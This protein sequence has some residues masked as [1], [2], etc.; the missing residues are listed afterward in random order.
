MQNY[1]P[2]YII[3]HRKENLKK[4]S[5]RG[6]EQRKDCIFLSY[7]AS[8]LPSFQNY[9][10]L[11]LEAEVELSA[12]EQAA[13]LLLLDATWRYAEKMERAVAHVPKRRLPLAARTAYPRR[14]TGCSDPLL[15]LASIEALAI[16]YHILGREFKTLLEGYYWREEFLRLNGEHLCN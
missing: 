9:L 12:G 1:L 13:G 14:Q 15:G 7:P 4:C 6:I 16:A 3:R 2:T 10:H 11:S 8:E 5:L